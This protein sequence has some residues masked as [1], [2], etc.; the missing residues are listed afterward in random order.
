[1]NVS[2]SDMGGPMMAQPN[3]M[4]SG[5]GTGLSAEKATVPHGTVSFLVTNTGSINH[6]MVVLPLG[7]SQTVGACPIGGDAKV[8]EAASLGEL[9]NTDGAGAGHGVTPGASN[10][11]T[12]TL[13]PGQHELVCNLPGHYTAGM[14]TQLTLTWRPTDAPAPG[15]RRNPQSLD[16]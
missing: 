2:L 13:A 5:G 3:G 16:A 6:E 10:W 4:I 11:I 8:D 14:Y 12:A 9:S 1:M 15:Y 7:H